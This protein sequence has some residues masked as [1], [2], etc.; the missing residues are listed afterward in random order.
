MLN[1]EK[2][3]PKGKKLLSPKI[4]VRIPYRMEDFGE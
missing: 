1:N 3:Q 4:D 2:L